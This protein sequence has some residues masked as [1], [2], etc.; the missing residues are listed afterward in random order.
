[1]DLPT[2]RFYSYLNQPNIPALNGIRTLAVILVILHHMGV[3]QWD[4]GDIGV[5][6]FFVLS[7]FLITWLILKE[8]EKTGRVSIRHFYLRRALR[9]LPAFYVFSLVYIILANVM[10]RQDD[11][12]QY[13]AAL[14]YFNDYY[15]WIHPSAHVPMDHTW[16]LAVEEQFYL[17]WP[18]VCVWCKCDRR[19]LVP[20][21]LWTILLVAAGR[22]VYQV[23]FS[24]NHSVVYYS[25]HTRADS[26]AIGCLLAALFKTGKAYKLLA[27]LI[28]NTLAPIPVLVLLGISLALEAKFGFPFQ[29]TVGLIVWPSLLAVLMI[30]WIALSGQ[31]MWSWLNA[32]PLNTMGK[33]SYAAYLWHWPIVYILNMRFAQIPR[34][35]T[36]PVAILA[37]FGVAAC[38]YYLIEQRFLGLRNR[39]RD[40]AAS[41][42]VDVVRG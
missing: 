23:Y 20:V 2:R 10:H 28:R 14:F 18:L 25:F 31:R 6:A 4:L 36:V 30:Q 34:L 15:R 22:V 37:S 13:L 32:E 35:I 41:V 3:T 1:V 11:W 33:W 24:G 29:H 7:G 39:F 27:V 5:I 12:D 40:Q 19:K 8:H 17:I 26:L 21:L 9:L 42:G 16:S 38:S